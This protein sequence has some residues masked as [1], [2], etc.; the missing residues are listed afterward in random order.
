MANTHPTTLTI[1]VGQ[2]GGVK[3]NFFH[4]TGTA[5]LDVGRQLHALL[6]EFGLETAVTGFTPKPE[7]SGRSAELM[8]SQVE[9]L[10]EGGR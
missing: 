4:F 6:T 2:D 8:V 7:L 1:T 10:Q 5:C 3:T 9:M